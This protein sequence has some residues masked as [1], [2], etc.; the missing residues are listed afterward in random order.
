MWL[1][2]A[3]I[4]IHPRLSQRQS[5]V[6]NKEGALLRSACT[7]DVKDPDSSMKLLS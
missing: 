5:E 3:S 7:A 4:C 1:V 6:P 2:T